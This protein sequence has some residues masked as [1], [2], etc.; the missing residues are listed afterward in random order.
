VEHTD[1]GE[2]YVVISADCHAGG[3]MDLYREFLERAWHDE[4]DAWRASYVV[5]FDDLKDDTTEAY[6]RNH[7]SAIRQ[8]ELEA[9]GIAAEVLFPNTIPPFFAR[10]GLIEGPPRDPEAFRRSW[11]GLR[12]HNRWLAAFCNELPGRR[13][14]VAQVWMGDLDLA[15]TEIEWSKLSGLFG[16]ILLPIPLQDGSQPPLHAPHYEPIWSLC[17]DLDVPITIHGGGGAPDEGW[18]PASGAVLFTTGGFYSLRPIA[19]LVMSGVFERHPRLR[20]ALT[21]TGTNTWPLSVFAH[22]D[23]F[24]DRC[25][26][27]PHSHGA[28]WAGRSVAQLSMKPSEYFARNCWHGASFMS[29]NDCAHRHEEGVDRIMWGAD[30]PHYEGTFPHTRASLRW[31]FQGVEPDEVRLMLAGNAAAMYGFDVDALRP[32]A[33]RIGPTVA[34]LAGPMDESEIPEGMWS[35]AFDPVPRPALPFP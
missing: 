33:D 22:L 12:A 4:Y 34:E 17:E 28:N 32:V 19:Q 6:R 10:H 13:A 27:V 24:V 15:R 16:G 11:A 18:F 14:G 23:W 20:V 21:E 7:D 9:E 25:A 35:E 1:S 26:R 31:T 2:R 29:R 30:Y 5:P 8:R 3:S